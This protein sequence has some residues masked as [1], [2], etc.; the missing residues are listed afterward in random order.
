MHFTS[1]KKSQLQQMIYI[2]DEKVQLQ[3][4]VQ[5]EDVK[6]ADSRIAGEMEPIGWRRVGQ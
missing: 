1:L 4:M 6:L 3:W 2:S 5:I